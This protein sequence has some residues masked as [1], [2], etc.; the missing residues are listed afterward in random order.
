MLLLLQ[1]LLI[2]ML[3]QG[4]FTGTYSHGVL[5]QAFTTYSHGVH[6]VLLQVLIVMGC[7]LSGTSIQDVDVDCYNR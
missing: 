2:V 1:V 5:L 3:L 4:T 7:F 6:G